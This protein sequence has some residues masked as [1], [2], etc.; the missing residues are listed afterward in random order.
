[1]E[2]KINLIK[3]SHNNLILYIPKSTFDVG[4]GD[5]NKYLYL[6]EKPQL[7]IKHIEKYDDDLHLIPVGKICRYTPDD[8]NMF[9]IYL[10]D[11][12]FLLV[13]GSTTGVELKDESIYNYNY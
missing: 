11:Y 4:K 6:V 13:R 8:N 2:I 10:C 1:M 5:I 12:T 7:V 3:D 9:T